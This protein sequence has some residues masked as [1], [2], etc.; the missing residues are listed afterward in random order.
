[1][2]RS[3]LLESPNN[4]ELIGCQKEP[5]HIPGSIQPHGVLLVLQEP[6]LKILHA[7][8]NTEDFFGI[9]AESLLQQDVTC[10]LNSF[11]AQNLKESIE[12]VETL[13]EA[14]PISLSIKSHRGH[15]WYNGIVHRTQGVL[16]LELEPSPPRQSLEFLDLY[17]PVRNAATK[18][19]KAS[20]FYGLCQ[21]VAREIRSL[22][23]FDRV[24]VYKFSN[25]EHGIVVGEDRGENIPSYLGLHYPSTDIPPQAR[26]LYLKNWL[27][28][29][30]DVNYEPVSVIP[31]RH[32]KTQKPLDFSYSV[33][34]SVSSRHLRYLQNM[35]VTA[36][37]SI[38]IIK[39]GQLW[40]LVAC[41]HHQRKYIPY[42]IRTACE[43]LGQ[44][45]SFHL[46]Y[47]ENQ[48][49][50]A[51]RLHL[52]TVQN[53]L[54]EYMFQ[55]ENFIDGLVKY[56]PNLLEIGKTEGAAICLDGE[57]KLVGKTPNQEQVKN[58]ARWLDGMDR[59]IFYT[60]SLIQYIPEAKTY[61]DMA[62]GLLAIA[63]APHQYVMWFRPE[64][65]HTVTWGRNPYYVAD[66]SNNDEPSPENS[67]QEWKEQVRYKSLEWKAGE[68]EA[69]TQLQSAMVKIVL[70]Q[71]HKLAQ[72]NKA[73]QESEQRERE[74]AEKL[75][76][77]LHELQRTQAQLIQNEKMS[78]LGQLVAGIAHEICNPVNFI[79][80]N[81]SHADTYSKDLIGLVDLYQQEYPSPT[82]S[83]EEE[84][85]EIDLEFLKEDLPKILSSM[86][87]GAERI[88]GLVQSLRS[89]SRVD[90]S[91]MKSVRIHEGIDSSL[92]ILNHRLK[93]R[94]DRPAIQVV[95]EYADLP[96]VECY[97]SQL[98]QVF[99]N[100]L[101]NALDALEERD[102]HRSQQEKKENPSQIT[103]ATESIGE[104][105]DG[106]VRVRIRDNGSGI[107]Q[108]D[109]ER[110]FEPFFTTKARD[111]G[112]G[113][114]LAISYQI[115]VE[116][117]HGSIQCN[118]QPGEGTE[119]VLEIPIQQQPES[120]NND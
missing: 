33:L 54:I 23:G 65:I 57:C 119:F 6:D 118:S 109:R 105:E 120:A 20:D 88:R 115:V 87:V 13:E 90:E 66:A 39:D 5:I 14:N 79:Y 59:E 89:F 32:Q 27:R 91:E 21:T 78:S 1:V 103:I 22:T 111:K 101:V 48:E 36:S 69:A 18:I 30:P 60:D 94:A 93:S 44:V 47:K 9:P 42:E 58:I 45:L 71:L 38:S 35:G 15:C 37:M 4:V 99:M 49:D 50:Y 34:R 110:I 56:Q 7:S 70:R 53:Q 67:F 102:R 61:K 64:V 28:I 41:H 46:P 16:F 107:S 10:L 74:K 80:G 82:K 117:H 73:L 68:I 25:E 112:T 24:M 43:F 95:K 83:I 116:K 19:Q 51:Y 40:G 55:E 96:L 12:Q 81:L 84:A 100:L 63:I 108:Q 3:A 98:N 92:L 17:H 26:E 86:Q 114:G 104:S 75:Q 106:W 52:K 113:M 62:S 72:M 31:E 11:Q 2:S 8:T 77:T 85:E 76:E 97:P 29:I